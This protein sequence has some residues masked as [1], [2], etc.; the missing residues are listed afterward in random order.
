MVSKKSKELSSLPHPADCRCRKCQA[1]RRI[2]LYAPTDDD[3]ADFI[4]AAQD[5][6]FKGN[7]SGF[8]WWLFKHYKL[9]LSKA[10]EEQ[11]AA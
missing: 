5:S 7:L 2:I 4:K 8:G 3:K 9:E 11:K 1:K 6:G 10:V